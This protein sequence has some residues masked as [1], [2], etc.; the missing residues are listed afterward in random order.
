MK[1]LL[2]IL[3]PVL[4][5][6]VAGRLLAQSDTLL[7][8]DGRVLKGSY[9]ISHNKQVVESNGT[10]NEVYQAE[11]VKR[12]ITPK[13]HF[14]SVEMD[15]GGEKNYFMAERLLDSEVDLYGMDFPAG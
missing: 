2:R 13:G 15:I 8:N 5:F 4:S 9:K 6:F 11:T 3:L 1:K 14:R 7:L 10:R 12:L